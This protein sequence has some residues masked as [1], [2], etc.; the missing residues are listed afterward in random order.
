MKLYTL[1]SS[2]F[3]ATLSIAAAKEAA[4]PASYR[5]VEDLATLPL[6]NPALN[7]RQTEKL[8]LANGLEVYLVSDP[9]VEQSA[10]GLAVEAGSWKDPKEYPGLAHF[11]EH[12]LFM[13]NEAYPKEFEYM[14]FISDHGGSVNAYTAS[15]RTVYMFSVNNDSFAPALDRFSHFFIDP[16]FLPHCIDRELHAVDQE[17]SKNIE[18]D[19]WRQYMILK[20]TGNR[21]HPNSGFS[22]GNAQTLSGIPQEALKKWYHTYYS[23]DRMH[24]VMI[25]PLPLDKLR[26]LAV[27]DFSKVA[28]LDVP[29]TTIQASLTSPLQKGHMIYIKPVRDIKQLSLLWEVPSEFALDIERKAP[30]LVAYVLEQEGKNSLISQLKEEKI[31]ESIHVSCDRFS[32]DTLLFSIDLSLTD[33][34]MTK[35]N[36]AISRIYETI[37]RLKQDGIPKYLFDELQTVSQLNYQYQSRD[38]AFST[39]IR[40]T[41]DLVYEEIATFPEKTRMPSIYDPNF[42]AKFINSLK[43]ENCVYFVLGNPAKTGVAPNLK[44]QWMAAEYAIKEIPASRLTAWDQIKVSQKIQLPQENPF[45][46]AQFNLVQKEENSGTAEQPLLLYSNDEAQVYFA[47]DSRYQVPEIASLFTFKS[48]LIDPTA[49]SQVLT[50]LYLR[51]LKE[52]LSSTLFFADNAKIHAGFH[53]DDLSIKLSVRGFSDKAPLLLHDIAASFREAAPSKDNFE[54]YKASLASDYDNA[55]KELPVRQASEVMDSVIFNKATNRDKWKAIQTISYEE[56]LTFS[57]NLFAKTYTQ[58]ML[59]GNLSTEQALELWEDLRTTLHSSPYPLAEQSKKQVLLLSNQDGP[60]M[61]SQ[62]TDRQ[63]HGVM[64]L[65]EEG[66]LT[67]KKR[68]AQQILGS[69]LSDAFFDT[70][71]TKQQTAY[72]AK[73]KAMEKERQLL[74]YFA[75]QSSTHYPSELLARFELFLEDFNKNLKQIVSKERFESIRANTITLLQMPPENMEGMAHKLN[76]LAF[77][78]GDFNWIN[79]RVNA[80]K[81]LSYE[82]FCKLTQEFLSRD[83]SRRLAVLVEG[84]L[85]PENDFRYEL[86]SKEEIHTVGSFV[87]V[88]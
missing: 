75:V 74:Q 65:I 51:A 7:E 12:M 68:G 70:L 39:V 77:E 46:P 54:I 78:Y 88:K 23:A 20:E 57:K 76:D 49:K 47:Q 37:A 41:D 21:N 67:F 3:L 2:L 34:G 32:K 4:P 16:L 30:A 18:H 81:E 71:R 84:V 25:S 52:Q 24:L 82:Q 79:K 15:D 14:Q 45:L 44:E 22:T 10:A 6:L 87:S 17:H 55:S 48:P 62:Q 9:G 33:F 40:L 29:E 58:A 56:F 85:P 59:Y 42:I 53:S 27:Q 5:I 1:L 38:D 72:I 13:G 19:G 83:N 61:L 64:L 80:C 63:G 50:D 60:Y 66:E 28:R 69:A 36:T 43:A 86:I 26:E 11:L 31:A 8:V 35:V 73:A